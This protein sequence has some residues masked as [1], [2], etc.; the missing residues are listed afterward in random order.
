MKTGQIR[1]EGVSR[2]FRVRA[3]EA[4]SLKELFVLGGRTEATD[5]VALQ[6]VSLAV[7]PGEAVGLVGRNGSGKSTLL[8]LIAGIIKPTEAASASAGGSARCSSSVRAS[9]PTS[10]VARTSF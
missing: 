8:R 10:P 1:V 6:D 9:T 7:E 5:V 3:N 2:R 4:R